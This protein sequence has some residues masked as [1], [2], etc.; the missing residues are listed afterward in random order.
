MKIRKFDWN[1]QHNY[2]EH[3]LP[4]DEECETLIR[5]FEECPWCSIRDI[6]VDSGLT[7]ENFPIFWYD[8]RNR[9][10]QTYKRR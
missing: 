8:V 7:D 1:K 2:D 9:T 4:T 3:R 10:M 6:L 5:M